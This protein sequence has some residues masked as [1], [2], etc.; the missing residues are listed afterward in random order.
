MENS[1][2]HD[3]DATHDRSIKSAKS[4]DE[5]TDKKK[6]KTAFL[7]YYDKYKITMADKLK[8]IPKGA[9]PMAILKKVYDEAIKSS[10]YLAQG[11]YTTDEILEQVVMRNFCTLKE[12]SSESAACYE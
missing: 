6:E 12:M 10:Q 3:T 8:S 1:T 9:D 2:K 11:K 5:Q 7:E 4:G